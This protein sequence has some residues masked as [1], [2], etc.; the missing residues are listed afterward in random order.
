[1]LLRPIPPQPSLLWLWVLA[2]TASTAIVKVSV[3]RSF[4]PQSY[5]AALWPCSGFRIPPVI[6]KMHGCQL[7]SQ[8]C[9][10]PSLRRANSCGQSPL[11]RFLRPKSTSRCPIP[12]LFRRGTLSKV[13]QNLGADPVVLGS[14]S[15]LGREPSKKLRLDILLHLRNELSIL[16]ETRAPVLSILRGQYLLPARLLGWQVAEMNLHS[17]EAAT[18]PRN[19][20]T[21]KSPLD[22]RNASQNRSA[23][24][25]FPEPLGS[26]LL[27]SSTEEKCARSSVDSGERS[28]FS[29]ISIPRRQE[30]SR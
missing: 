18:R 6:S 16:A 21:S 8:K 7:H 13:R 3:L 12:M 10:R 29:I 5:R 25:C 15:T 11:K 22:H 1:M 23:V 2:A 20:Q 17:A 26:P 28:S 9:S 19:G 14:F 4:R 30:V 27:T 24:L